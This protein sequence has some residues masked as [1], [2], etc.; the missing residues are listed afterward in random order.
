[1]LQCFKVKKKQ[2]CQQDYEYL[3][4]EVQEKFKEKTFR[5]IV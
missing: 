2:N 3:A 5:V 1:M 4:A